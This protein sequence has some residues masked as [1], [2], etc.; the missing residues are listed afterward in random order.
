MAWADRMLKA[1]W[2]ERSAM[3]A[4]TETDLPDISRIDADARE[5]VETPGVR[6]WFENGAKIQV[7]EDELGSAE[8]QWFSPDQVGEPEDTRVVEDATRPEVSI[9][10]VGLETVADYLAFEDEAEL[11]EHWGDE[12]VDVLLGR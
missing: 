6:I 9:A 1:E 8:R 11:R 4:D 10:E 3:N 12:H 7:I 2:V 5:T